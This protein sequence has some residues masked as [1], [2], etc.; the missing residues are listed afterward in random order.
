[1][2]LPF[3]LLLLRIVYLAQLEPFRFEVFPFPSWATFKSC[4]Q[5]LESCYNSND[6]PD[7][8]VGLLTLAA[9][10]ASSTTLCSSE[11]IGTSVLVAWSTRQRHCK[12]PFTPCVKRK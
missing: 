2:V 3:L 8:G 11:V 9:R 6:V 5:E 7:C 10:R 12:G 4:N 1:M